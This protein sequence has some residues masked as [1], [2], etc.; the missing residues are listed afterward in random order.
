[1]FVWIVLFSVIPF[2]LSSAA[3]PLKI[4]AVNYPLKYFA[5]RIGGMHVKVYFPAPADVDPVYWTPDITS[6][7]ANQKAD[8]I[9]LNGAGYAKWGGLGDARGKL[10]FEIISDFEL[11]FLTNTSLSVKKVNSNVNIPRASRIIP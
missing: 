5:E 1:M 7:A 6:I 8:L 11:S 3:G 10:I 2:Q 9:L 4:Y